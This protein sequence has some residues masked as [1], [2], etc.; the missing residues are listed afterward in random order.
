MFWE[1]LVFL[2]WSCF[3][4]ATQAA[5]AIAEAWMIQ[6]EWSTTS[7][8]IEPLHQHRPNQPRRSHRHADP[9]VGITVLIGS[10]TSIRPNLNSNSSNSIN[11]SINQFHHPTNQNTFSTA[12][13]P[14]TTT[15]T[16]LFTQE[17]YNKA[18]T[19]IYSISATLPK[20]RNFQI[21][22]NSKH[23]RQS[24][25]GK[26]LS[27]TTTTVNQ[28]S[29]VHSTNTTQN[30]TLLPTLDLPASFVRGVP[31]TRISTSN[32]LQKHHQESHHQ[33]VASHSDMAKK[34]TGRQ[35]NPS[36]KSAPA[37]RKLQSQTPADSASSAGALK[38]TKLER[39]GIKSFRKPAGNRGPLPAAPGRREWHVPGAL[40]DGAQRQRRRAPADPRG[41]LRLH[42]GPPHA[43]RGVCDGYGL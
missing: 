28:N 13:T 1:C 33:H 23:I 37:S 2:F 8:G 10:A 15:T 7:I 12:Y 35:K 9:P 31:A 17:H 18:N 6:R 25:N 5:A 19:N 32:L 22:S 4:P 34:Q 3:S 14:R 16:I 42:F 21:R 24:N 26:R 43:V 40:A 41:G 20:Y 39:E 30:F 29:G 27:A 36:A 11:C 38:P